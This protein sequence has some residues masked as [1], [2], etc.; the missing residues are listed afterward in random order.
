MN[1]SSTITIKLGKKQARHALTVGTLAVA[2]G[3]GY[4]LRGATVVAEQGGASTTPPAVSS[5]VVQT[6]A[7][8]D[9]VKMQ[10]AFQAVART[11]APAVV[12]V[13]TERK[14]TAAASPRGRMQPFGGDPFGGGGDGEDPF[15]EFWR[16]FRG[17]GFGPKGQSL[18]KEEARARFYQL[19]GQGRG[20]GLG[21]GMIYRE[22]GLILTN[23]HVVRGAD[24]VTIKLNDDREFKKAKV[25]GVDTRTDVAVIKIDVK[26]EKLPTVKFGDSSKVQV[27]DWAIA[28]GNPFNLSHTVTIGVISATAREV[29][30]NERS[31]GDYLQ[32]DASINPGNSGGPLL[33]IY[34]RVIGINNAIYSQSGGNI[35]I[36]F[37]VPIN[38]ARDIADQLVKSGKIV[39]GYLGVRISNVEDE[40]EAFGLNP[41]TKGA[42]VVE[43]NK[44]TPGEKAGL[45]PGDVV[46]AFNG[47][48]VTRS[49]EL[50]R[51]VGNAPV[52]S[53][54]E[55]T[56]LRDGKTITLTAI[57]EELKNEGAAEDEEGEEA[58]APR[59]ETG[60][61]AKD[62]GVQLKTLTPDV[63]ES[64]GLKDRNA[65]GVVITKVNPDSP[66]ENA[67]LQRGDVIERVGQT[68]VTTAQDVLAAVKNIL[69]RQTEEEKKVA[70][71]V[72]SRGT[73]KLVIVTVTK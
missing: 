47:K 46:T 61:S 31:P 53:K 23:A 69:G 65:K 66:A 55:L 48:P 41:N 57:L 22:D 15:E 49:S 38:S 36:G 30:L 58:P 35:G 73:K 25:L 11:A 33:D 45:Q 2:L 19:Q 17:F 68:P 62:L 18:D 16:R 13:R 37:A 42:L 9:A 70:L 5:P 4:A 52:G 3:T 39:R 10:E 50:Q 34:G 43:V 1:D 51:L 28:V 67:G 8:N 27:G 29:P 54:A 60:V 12:T 71:F 6:A 7:T 63:A 21:S 64:F 26:N 40:A 56:V 72:N 44:G 59:D 20:S 32:T 14:V 24:T